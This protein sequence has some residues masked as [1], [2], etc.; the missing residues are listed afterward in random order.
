MTTL[1]NRRLSAPSRLPPKRPRGA[2]APFALAAD[3]A[4]KRTSSGISEAE[5]SKKLGIGR[6][7]LRAYEQGAEHISAEICCFRLQSSSTCGRTTSS[8]A[9]AQKN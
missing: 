1:L 2:W 3:C 4:R 8:K 7:D 5:F 9:T 6:A